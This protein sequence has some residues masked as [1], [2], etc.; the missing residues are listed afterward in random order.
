[1]GEF[2]GTFRD[3][4]WLG[5]KA[6]KMLESIITID[7][8]ILETGAGSSSLWFAEKAHSVISF[9]HKY[10]WGIAVREEAAKR[11]LTNLKV[12]I[13]PGYPKEGLEKIPMMF[14]LIVIDGRGRV[15]SLISTH[16]KLRSG[17]YMVLDNSNRAR[18]APALEFL[19][20]QGWPRRDIA[21]KVLPENK[22]GFTSF[23]RKP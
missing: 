8:T 6:I 20:R 17:G 23:W 13:D 5:E 14:D 18:Y 1:M 15:K 11:N 4:P 9:E 10:D 16:K 21:S 22:N 12:H 19:E 3:G 7:T 2:T